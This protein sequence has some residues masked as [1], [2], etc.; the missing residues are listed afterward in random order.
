V[1]GKRFPGVV[2]FTLVFQG[3]PLLALSSTSIADLATQVAFPRSLQPSAC[4]ANPPSCPS[5]RDLGKHIALSTIQHFL[6]EAEAVGLHPGRWI[7]CGQAIVGGT[8]RPERQITRH[9]TQG[10]NCTQIQVR[11]V[12]L[13]WEGPPMK[14]F[15]SI[16]LRYICRVDDDDLRRRN[17]REEGG[18]V[19]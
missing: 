11:Y 13:C 17:V 19:E 14:A 9:G 1:L 2:L 6:H 15:F 4:P 3:L 8:R 18:E 16:V 7:S 5:D 10:R 12:W